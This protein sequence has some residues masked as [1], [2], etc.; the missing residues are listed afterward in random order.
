MLNKEYVIKYIEFWL[1]RLDDRWKTF[2]EWDE[3]VTVHHLTD[4]NIDDLIELLY[5]TI[6]LQECALFVLKRLIKKKLEE[7][8]M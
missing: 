8:K 6:K 2:Q 1:E 3:Y 5:Y 7:V 4:Q